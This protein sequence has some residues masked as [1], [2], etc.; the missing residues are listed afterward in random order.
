[1]QVVNKNSY[2]TTIYS[3][4]IVNNNTGQDPDNKGRV[5]IY[6]PSINYEYADVYQEY[7][8]S[9]DKQSSKYKDAFPWALK[10]VDEVSNGDEVYGSYVEGDDTKFIILGKAGGISTSSQNVGGL[11]INTS[12]IVNLAM[13]I[14]IHNEVGV[15]LSAWS[16]DTIPDSKYT[17]ITLH[18]GGEYND[19]TKQWVKQGSW[20]IGL[21]QWNGPRAFDVL[22]EIAKNDGNWRVNFENTNSQLET[23]IQVCKS[24]GSTATYRNRYGEGYNPEKG[25]NTYNAIVS[26]LSSDKAKQTQKQ[27]AYNAT[28]DTINMLVNEG[29]TNPAI[30]IYLADFFNQYGSGHSETIAT[31]VEACTGSGDM[32]Q[33]LD[34]VI[35]FISQNFKSFN[36]YSTR[37]N[38]TYS[39]IKDLF[40]TGRLNNTVLTDEDGTTYLG[41][42]SYCVPFKGT[43]SISALWGPNG[44]LTHRNREGTRYHTGVDFACPSGTTLIA[45]TNGELG[46]ISNS[47]SDGY[48]KAL[49]IMADDGN[50]IIYGHMSGFNKTS[51]RVN[52]G[53]IIGYSGNTGYS[54]G[55]HLHFEV[56]KGPGYTANY[57]GTGDDIDPLPLIGAGDKDR[58]QYVS[59]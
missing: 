55:A 38:A 58:D 21:I 44:Y 6:I 54:I 13:P 28:F 10:L 59:G 8:E 47:L 14:I 19:S 41:S 2:I 17:A 43:Y 36:T 29:C 46:V 50:M 45:C 18:D 40:N 30:L 22:Y 9:A 49:K 25:G 39:Y 15:S 56:R 42:G 16:D 26:M 33:Q 27:L 4:I 48:G 52:K 34:Y 57:F 7:M 32:M 20:S 5:Q 37:R 12:N 35:S 1:M 3:A 11:D 51:G 53:D 31:A 24:M 23:D